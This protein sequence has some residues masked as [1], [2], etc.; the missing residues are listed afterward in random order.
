MDE[1]T[2]EILSACFNLLFCERKAK[3]KIENSSDIIRTVLNNIYVQKPKT[4]KQETK[5]TYIPERKFIEGIDIGER[6]VVGL[7]Y[8]L[9]DLPLD[10][11]ITRDY[12][13]QQ[14]HI[15]LSSSNLETSST[16]KLIAAFTKSMSDDDISDTRLKKI[17]TR[18]KLDLNK[19]FRENNIVDILDEAGYAFKYKRENITDVNVFISDLITKL[20]PYQ[21]DAA[22]KD[23]GILD[24]L[25]IGN[26][27]K[28]NEIFS[29]IKKIN[30]GDK[31]YRFGWEGLNIMTQGGIRPGETM[32]ISALQHKYKT[33]FSLTVFKQLALYN[34]PLTTDITK[35]PLLL[36]I[37]FE[38]DLTLNL[39]FLYQSLKY[40]ETREDVDVRNVSSEEMASY[41]KARLQ[42]NGFHIKLI[43]V[44]PTQWTYKSIFNK[45]IELESEG[46]NIE[47]L[48]IDYLAMVPT[49][50]CVSTGALGTDIR[51][52][53]RRVRNFCSF[54]GIAFITP[55]QLSSEAKQLLRSG[56]PEDQFVKE[57]TEKGYFAGTKQL[58]QEM[59]IEVYIHLFKHGKDSYLAVQRGKHRIPT[60]IPEEHKYY[61]MKFPK[62]MP[63]PDSVEGIKDYYRKLPSSSSN[64]DDSL[65]TM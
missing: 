21:S 39:Q 45:I 61:L 12:I 57:V 40:D 65:F 24:D 47:I 5:K 30:K 17:I 31:I 13:Q 3:E 6:N 54:R 27:F 56:L 29:S 25:D 1:K 15:C 36:R 51:D 52:L 50:G 48:M 14:L 33:G 42:V 58:D 10:Q 35:K 46:Y 18:A 7:I 16:E 41:V 23:P 4:T 63:I 43:R 26:D 64:Q 49:I 55:H 20:E 59:D 53:L 34:K 9:C 44:D 28:L 37:S 22:I 11:E 60:I 62:G 2:N 38:D 19:V 8:R 32:V